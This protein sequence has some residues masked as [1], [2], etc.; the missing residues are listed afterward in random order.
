MTSQR[1]ITWDAYDISAFNGSSNM[2][3]TAGG[4]SDFL[5]L[6]FDDGFLVEAEEENRSAKQGRQILR[7]L[8]HVKLIKAAN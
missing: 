5:V 6:L 8:T 7:E 2:S 4:G 1:A 3:S